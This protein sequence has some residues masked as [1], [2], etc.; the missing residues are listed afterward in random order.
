MS[1]INEALKKARSEATQEEARRRGAPYLGLP[2]HVPVGPS[3]RDFIHA[4]VAVAVVL[5]VVGGLVWLDSLQRPAVEPAAPTWVRPQ[6]T[7]TPPTVKK[8]PEKPL[9]QPA[10]PAEAPEPPPPSSPVAAPEPVRR[11]AALP[12]SVPEPAA[13]EPPVTVLPVVA[14]RP[15]QTTS[16]LRVAKLIGNVELKL[17]FIVWSDKPFAQ[18]NDVLLEPGQSIEGYELIGIE[19]EKVIFEGPQ[20]K[21]EIR[22][23]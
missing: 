18:V 5:L 21:I 16:F 7:V 2:V 15:S 9:E 12:A 19:R 22:A 11:P 17:E 23:R 10:L 8:P 20:G 3:R 1:L 14:P 6:R 13:D 4:G